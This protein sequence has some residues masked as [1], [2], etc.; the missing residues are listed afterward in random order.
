MRVM[1]DMQQL[2]C[3][4]LTRDELARQGNGT[5][6]GRWRGGWGGLPRTMRDR[7]WR[8]LD[9][10]LVGCMMEWREDRRGL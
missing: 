1:H 2:S 3:R 5:V 6:R 4:S 10:W 8:R 7:R 9:G